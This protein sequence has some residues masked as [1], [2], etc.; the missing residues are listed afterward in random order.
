[1]AS[2]WRLAGQWRIGLVLLEERRR[3][4]WRRFQCR[5]GKWVF[6]LGTWRSTQRAR[7]WN[8]IVARAQGLSEDLA[9]GDDSV[10]AV[11]YRVSSRRRRKNK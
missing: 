5:V 3:G 1:M 7:R 6:P 11:A 2:R 9:A 8:T 4:Q 10:Y